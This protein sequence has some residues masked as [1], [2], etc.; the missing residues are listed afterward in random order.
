MKKLFAIVLS[1][2]LMVSAVSFACAEGKTSYKIGI[3]NLV[4][5][6][7]LIQIYENIVAGLHELEDKY[8]VSFD[9]RYENCN[10]DFTVLDQIIADFITD[11]VDLMFGIATPVAKA[12][13]TAT[14][15]NGIPVVFAAVSDPVGSQLVES[16]E[17]P[18]GNVTGSSDALNTNAI[19]DLIFTYKPE[20]QKIALLYNP[21]EDASTLPIADA[22]AL[23]DSKGVSYFEYP[24]TNTPEVQLAVDALIQDGVD[25]V[26][27]PTDN[28]IQ[29]AEP[30]IS[31]A[32]AEAGIA[33]FAGADSFA[34]VGAF[35]GYGV[36]YAELGRATALYAEEI[37]IAGVS[38]AEL[39]V[40]TFDNGKA[41]V[42]TDVCEALGIT[43]ENIA[44]A[45]EPFCTKVES[46]ETGDSFAN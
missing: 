2:I 1:L 32:L 35:V 16:M 19:F 8:Q 42:N 24:G 40:R 3:A 6:P 38:P 34:L 27:T 12:M 45:F 4:D 11:E 23:L 26:F 44:A 33:H 14:E 18:G 5:D 37:L 17:V 21:S 15:D 13:L 39:P 31:E 29:V 36:D 10:L 20:A 46:I 41:T 22:K 7:S 30:A 28:T 43:Y 25:A 9:I